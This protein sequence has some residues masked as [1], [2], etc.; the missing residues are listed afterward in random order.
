MLSSVL[1]TSQRLRA[2]RP[3]SPVRVDSNVV[4]GMCTVEKP[5]DSEL[6][7]RQRGNV[8]RKNQMLHALHVEVL[9]RPQKMRFYSAIDPGVTLQSTNRVTASQGC[10]MMNGTVPR[11]RRESLI[12]HF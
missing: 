10:L 11:V 2:P 6:R 5:Y 4:C 3:H 7:R 9:I 1:F 12:L 8:L